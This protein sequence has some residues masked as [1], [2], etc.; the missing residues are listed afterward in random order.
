MF[1]NIASRKVKTFNRK[2]TIW[3]MSRISIGMRLLDSREMLKRAREKLPERKS[4]ATN[5]EWK[6]YN[7]F[8]E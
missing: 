8:H 2:M 4:N 1:S 7:F 5:F 6:I 3:I